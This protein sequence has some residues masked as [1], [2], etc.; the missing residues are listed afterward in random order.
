MM[1]ILDDAK[2]Q[3]MLHDVYPFIIAQAPGVWL[4]SP[5][6][7]KVWQ[8]WFKG[9]HGESNVGYD[10]SYRHLNYVWIDSSLKKSAK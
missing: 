5:S 7:Y 8:P 4:P 10:N 2:W 3:K 1:R 9:W 6:A